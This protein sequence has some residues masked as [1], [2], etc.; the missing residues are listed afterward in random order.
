MFKV[1][2]KDL[3]KDLRR[4]SNQTFLFEEINSEYEQQMIIIFNKLIRDELE[5]SIN[6]KI[7]AE[8]IIGAGANAIKTELQAHAYDEFEHFNKLVSYASNHGILSSLEFEVRK[9]L[10]VP[11]YLPK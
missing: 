6:Y 1:F 8:S 5:A 2:V 11:E 4:E 7:M 3:E 10:I 9:E